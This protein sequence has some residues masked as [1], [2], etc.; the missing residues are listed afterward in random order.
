[1]R[2]HRFIQKGIDLSRDSVEINEKEIVHQITAVLRLGAGDQLIIS[3]GL[4]SAAEAKIA[5]TTKNSVQ[6]SI[7]KRQ[8]NTEKEN[9]VVLYVSI[10]KKDILERIVQMTTEIGVTKIVP[11]VCDRTVK[12]GIVLPRLE[13]IATEAT[14]L[15]GRFRVPAIET[16]ITF[17][18]ALERAKKEGL[19]TIVLDKNG[20]RLKSEKIGGYALFVG[21]EGGFTEK[22]ILLA[23]EIGASIIS[24]GAHTLR[25]ET[26][27][28]ASVSIIRQ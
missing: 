28:V 27:A 17:S 18:E 19:N 12:T 20:D 9:A 8:K 13:K 16:P 4:D 14:E 5:S 24:L 22:E 25:V 10:P 11:I 21:P 6:V 3:D 23:Q 26:A 15:S 7:L 2:L 1:M